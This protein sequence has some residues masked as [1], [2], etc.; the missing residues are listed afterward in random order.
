VMSTGAQVAA[1]RARQIHLGVARPP[2]GDE[3]LVADALQ[4]EPVVVAL[5]AGHPLAARRTVPLRALAGDPFV[6]FPRD[7]RPGWYDFVLGLCREAGFQPQT[8]EEAPEIATA[9]ALVSAGSGVTL[10]PASVQ[11][12]QREGIAYRALAAPAPR[13]TLIALRRPGDPLPVVDRFLA[14][15]REVLARSRTPR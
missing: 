3:T 6:L 10:V 12:V 9:I 2:F 15:A 8:V 5:P 1:L 13:T 11:E 14:V 7:L 4:E